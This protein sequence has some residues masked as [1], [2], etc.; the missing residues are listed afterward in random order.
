[1]GKFLIHLLSKFFNDMESK[2]VE[3]NKNSPI[4]NRHE[5]AAYNMIANFYLGLHYDNNWEVCGWKIK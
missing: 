2:Y 4:M 5:S 1:M 3:S